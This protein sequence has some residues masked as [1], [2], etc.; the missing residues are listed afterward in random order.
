MRLRSPGPLA[1]SPGGILY[2]V[3]EDRV[4]RLLPSEKF[5][6][7]AGSGRRGFSGDGGPATRAELR[8][9][10]S[11]VVGADGTVYIADTG[12]NRVRAV[13]PD[14]VIRT[15]VRVSRPVGLAIGHGRLYIG[16]NYL[17]SMP[18]RGERL[19]RLAGW[20]G[21]AAVMTSH[22]IM[23]SH[24]SNTYGDIAVDR[25]GDVF[26][27]NF[28]QLY[29]RTAAGRLRFLGNGFRAS[30]AGKLTDGPGGNVYEGTFGVAHISTAAPERDAEQTEL[31][32]HPRSIVSARRIDTAVGGDWRELADAKGGALV[33]PAAGLAVA[34]DGTIYYDSDSGDG[35]A[36]G[37]LVEI[38][39][40]GAVRVLWRA[41]R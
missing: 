14:G 5:A 9:G 34:A 4:L 15:L 19:R 33:A 21:Q 22:Q 12:N 1:V 37:A 25:A 28:P 13:A 31:V 20:T 8:L 39:P 6:V 11:I 10:G 18:L 2:V 38:K 30:G 32:Q 27:A 35:W 36:S 16:A 17:Y 29:E 3:D 26:V 7:F 24:F 41:P 23:E 40:S